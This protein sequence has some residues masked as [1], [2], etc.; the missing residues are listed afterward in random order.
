MRLNNI[1]ATVTKRFPIIFNNRKAC[2]FCKDTKK[3]FI[4]KT[5]FDVRIVLLHEYAHGLTTR[6]NQDTYKDEYKAHL[7][8]IRFL[9]NNSLTLLKK[10]IKYLEY[11][12]NYNSCNIRKQAA[13]DAILKEKGLISKHKASYISV[14]M[15]I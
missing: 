11:E 15:P 8:V 2:Y 1:I 10:Y 9:K 12:I 14:K 4:G 6:L 3:I 13:I 7:W 5:A